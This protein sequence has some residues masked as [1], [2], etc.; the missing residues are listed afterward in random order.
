MQY[1]VRTEKGEKKATTRNRRVRENE[2]AGPVSRPRIDSYRIGSTDGELLDP[3]ETPAGSISVQA[4]ME[5][6]LVAS[7]ERGG[8]TY[9]VY[10][11]LGASPGSSWKKAPSVGPSGARTLSAQIP[12]LFFSFPFRGPVSPRRAPLGTHSGYGLCSLH[13]GCQLSSAGAHLPHVSPWAT[14][15]LWV[16]VNSANFH[17]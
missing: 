4:R 9:I 2:P 5:N 3:F 10:T 17:Q 8:G 1:C 16:P 15:L 11:T 14:L 13:Y 12:T 7:C 6:L